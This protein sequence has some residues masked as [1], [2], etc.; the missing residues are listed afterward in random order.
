M[1]C[2]LL[3]FFLYF[4]EVGVRLRCWLFQWDLF[5]VKVWNSS[6]YFY[7]PHYFYILFEPNELISHTKRLTHN[8][9]ICQE[10]LDQI[11]RTGNWTEI[12]SLSFHSRLA[13]RLRLRILGGE[14]A[15]DCIRRFAN[16]LNES[17][18]ATAVVLTLD[19]MNDL[20]CKV[21]RITL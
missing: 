15:Q 1:F 20:Q 16:R 13:P 2:Q 7:K 21:M 17:W 18:P 10:F 9:L 11:T 8:M 12:D 4:N 14:C 19:W 6:Y 3:L 5:N